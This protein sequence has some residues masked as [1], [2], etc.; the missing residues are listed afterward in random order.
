MYLFNGIFTYDTVDKENVSTSEFV[1]REVAGTTLTGILFKQKQTTKDIYENIDQKELDEIIQKLG[2]SDGLW[3]SYFCW[4]GSLESVAGIQFKDDQLLQSTYRLSRDIGDD[5]IQEET[6]KE[7]M[8]NYN[9]E[10]EDD[11]C[12]PPFRRGYWDDV[13]N[14]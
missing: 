10:L 9:I 3:L 14:A 11:G 5:T 2:I 8:N 13:G 12:F 4:G 7:L 6:F 1:I